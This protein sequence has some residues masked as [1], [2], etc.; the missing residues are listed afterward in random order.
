MCTK[1]CQKPSWFSRCVDFSWNDPT[2]NQYIV[3]ACEMLAV[4]MHTLF[5]SFK[6]VDIDTNTLFVSNF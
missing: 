2:G 4:D 6:W 3:K 1:F 5:T